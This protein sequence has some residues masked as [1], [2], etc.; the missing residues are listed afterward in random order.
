M[1][2]TNF[3]AIGAGRGNFRSYAVGFA[4]S[5][6]LTAIAFGLAVS[7]VQ[8]RWLVLT[9]IFSVGIAQILVHFH[10]FLHLNSS[11]STRW[12]ILA[13]ILTVLIIALFVGGTLWIM[14]HLKYRLL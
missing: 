3:D 8:P 6:L 13:L 11:S 14:Y 5:F 1:N 4:L 2:Q 9:V 7:G 12:N 10:Y